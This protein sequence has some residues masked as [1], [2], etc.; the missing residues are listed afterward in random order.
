MNTSSDQEQIKHV[1]KNS[2]G[3]GM[4]RAFLPG[5]GPSVRIS[6]IVEYIFMKWY[7]DHINRLLR[8]T[9]RALT[10]ALVASLA[11]CGGDGR[12]NVGA[13]YP[14]KG[15]V[16][17][18]DGKAPP[19]RKVVFSG[20]SPATPPPGAT[21]HSPSRVTTPG[22]RPESTRSGWRSPNPRGRPGVRSPLPG[23]VSATKIPPTSTPR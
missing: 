23:Q 22:C 4:G 8:R 18:A 11:G 7:H 14:V 12:P 20:R 5:T 21:G 19:G 3:E 2:T 10:V 9:A 6:G 16:T 17:L 1:A 15:K 13:A